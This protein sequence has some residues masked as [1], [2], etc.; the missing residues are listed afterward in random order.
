MVLFTYIEWV[1]VSKKILFNGTKTTVQKRYFFCW[2]C[3]II[4]L[5]CTIH[6]NINV[7]K[8]PNQNK[9]MTVLPGG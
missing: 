9:H 3:P 5:F 4:T 7:W 8:Q 2:Y 6:C 1:H